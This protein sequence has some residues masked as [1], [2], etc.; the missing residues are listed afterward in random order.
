MDLKIFGFDLENWQRLALD[1]K[2]WKSGV[3]KGTNFCLRRW[4]LEHYSD[5]KYG[6]ED[7]SVKGRKVKSLSQITLNNMHIWKPVLR[8]KI[9]SKPGNLLAVEDSDLQELYNEF[10]N[11]VT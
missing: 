6:T 9:T 11:F 10:A 4:L 1:E 2:A 7:I 5:K 8:E 3:S